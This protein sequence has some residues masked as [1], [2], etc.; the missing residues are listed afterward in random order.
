[1][2]A[3]AF[4]QPG[5]AQ[6]DADGGVQ[7]SLAECNSIWNQA[8]PSDADTITQSQAE[9][10][11]TDFKAANP[12]GDGTLSQIEFQKACQAGLVRS[13]ASSGAAAG[14]SGHQQEQ[15]HAP[16]NRMDKQVPTMRSPG[17]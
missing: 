1:M 16:T 15:L 4:A 2:A 14:E 6:S 11:V 17:N 8:N 7:L 3:V 9:P 5:M 12:D 10:Y 13:S